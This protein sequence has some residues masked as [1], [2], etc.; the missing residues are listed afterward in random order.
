[1]SWKDLWKAEI[2]SPSS[3]A[4][5]QVPP[6]LD[7]ET[8]DR[9]DEETVLFILRGGIRL[10]AGKWGVSERTLRRRFQRKRLRLCDLLQKRRR[11]MTLR[12]LSGDLPV[13]A[14]AERLG[15]SSSQSFA[16]Y[17]RRE[18]GATARELR[19]RQGMPAE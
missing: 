17:V 16:R 13:G 18:F 7:G 1:L 4:R 12:L 3:A 5:S 15:F 11:D 19:R 9:L 10:A 2:P 8:L 6:E 14:V